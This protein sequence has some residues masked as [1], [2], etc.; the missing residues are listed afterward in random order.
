MWPKNKI[1]LSV[2]LG[3]LIVSS[4]LSVTTCTISPIHTATSTSQPTDYVLY[5]AWVARTEGIL[6][7]EEGCIRIKKPNE[8]RPGDALAWPPDLEKSIEDGR[9]WVVSGLVSGHR[10]EY[11]IRFGERVVLSGGWNNNLDEQ[12]LGTI[13]D[14]CPGPYFVVGGIMEPAPVTPEP[15]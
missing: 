14:D 13:P 7:N 8:N 4:F 10:Q 9:L 5:T 15:K 12:L 6:V 11:I 3:I 2:I 1:P